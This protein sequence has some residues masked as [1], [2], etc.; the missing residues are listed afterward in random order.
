[1]S[2]VV[3]RFDTLAAAKYVASPETE[4]RID[5]EQVFGDNVFSLHQMAARLPKAQYEALLSTIEN[6][7]ELDPN[8]ADSVATAMKEWAIEKGATH[9]THWFQPLTGTSA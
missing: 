2:R 3:P 4:K 7:T 5:L 8:V 9:F 6:G 1:M